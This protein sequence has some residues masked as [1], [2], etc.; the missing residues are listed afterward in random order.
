MGSLY[1]PCSRSIISRSVAP[2][3]LG[4]TLGTI[5]TFESFAAIVSPLVFGWV[6][7][8]TLETRPSTIFYLASF[9]AS[10]GWALAVHIFVTHRRASRHS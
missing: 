4:D 10:A 8:V 6:Y 5:A 2:E 9:M 1:F 7:S 3:I